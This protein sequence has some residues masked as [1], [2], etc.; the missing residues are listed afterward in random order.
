ML[1][2]ELSAVVSKISALIAE[3]DKILVAAHLRPDGDATGSVSGLVKSLMKA[4]K[5]VDA[6]LFDGV[7]ERFAFVFPAIEVLRNQVIEA[8]HDLIIILDSGDESRTGFTFNRDPQKTC[9]INIDHHASN[10]MFGDINYVDT[11][12]SS[13]CEMVAALLH[14]ADL[15]FDSEVALS[16]MLGLVTDSRSFQNEGI[17]ASAHLAAAKILQTGVDT[18]PILNMLNSG[19]CE[20]DLRVQ[21]FGLSN[22][23]LH[24]QNRLA[25]LIIRHSDL[26]GL[27]A[28][29]ANVFASGLFNQMLSISETH[30]SVVIFEREDGMSF[31]EFRSRGGIDVKEVAV[32]MGGGGHVPASGCSRAVAVD[33]LAREAIDRMTRQ[34]DNFFAKQESA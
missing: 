32:A 23:K 26:T 22:F 25:T 21:G 17:R 3:S 1:P 14:H 6:A 27:N 10:T 7:P 11:G 5:K 13:A 12:A 9:L 24:C 33:E 34:V 19:K 8:D 16:L 30:A 18:R 20:A 31:C 29:F 28:S 4:G 2:T 15:P